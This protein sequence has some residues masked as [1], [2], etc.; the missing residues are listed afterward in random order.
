M[1]IK[2]KINSLHLI[3]GSVYFRPNRDM[4]IT[5]ELFQ[6]SLNTILQDYGHLSIFIGGNFNA[7]VGTEEILTDEFYD[8]SNF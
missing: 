3:I 1:L 5:L 6:Y 4:K 8:Q 2:V 7:R